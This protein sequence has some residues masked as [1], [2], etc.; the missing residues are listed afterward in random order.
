MGTK[1]SKP[2]INAP[3]FD[4]TWENLYSQGKHFNRYPYTSVVS[5]VYGQLSQQ[6]SF[7]D[8]HALEVGCGAGNNLWFAAREGMRVTGIDASKSAI[9]YAIE[10]FK[11]E[12]LEG[13]FHVGDFILLPFADSSFDIAIDRAA[14]T[15]TGL[16][17]AYKATLEINRTLRPG[18]KFYSELFS[19]QTTDSGYRGSDNLIFDIKGLYSGV[20]QIC[21]YSESQIVQLFSAGWKILD[22]RHLEISRSG[23]GAKEVIGQWNIL[24]EKV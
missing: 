11:S 12:N 13:D 15:S 22:L 14:I 9:N 19:S 7:R 21:L 20:G 10:R 5:F 6:I 4:D 3:S 24:A 8:L 1:D 23:N 2:I 17:N 16:S 18:G